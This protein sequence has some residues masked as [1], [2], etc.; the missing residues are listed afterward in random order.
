[1]K[2]IQFTLLLILSVVF[3][4]STSFAVG[5][6]QT[7]VTTPA[8]T[9]PQAQIDHV[10]KREEMNKRRA[11]LLKLRQQLIESDSPGNVDGTQP[12]K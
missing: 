2:M 9:V 11:E 4:A 12:I 8:G 1:M 5:T 3:M 7:V 10:A 6:E